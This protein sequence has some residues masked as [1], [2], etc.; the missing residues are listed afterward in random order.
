MYLVELALNLFWLA[1]VLPAFVLW[2]RRASCDR[3]PRGSLLF[4][5]TLGC[6]L[7]LLFPVISA[8]DDLHSS[9]QAM[10]ESKRIFRG[11][12]HCNDHCSP[13]TVSNFSQP[14]LP[15]S[16]APRLAYARSAT[17]SLSSP[18]SPGTFVN[19]RWMGRAPPV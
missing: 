12:N 7:V 9:S 4:V 1:L 16:G 17:V 3:S 13:P 6:V 19:A 18:P 14:A 8:S 5:C 11:G 15:A 2:Q 10:E